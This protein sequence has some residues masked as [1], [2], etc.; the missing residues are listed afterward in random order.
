MAIIDQF[1]FH[2]ILLEID[3]NPVTFFQ[4]AKVFFLDLG[5]S[6]FEPLEIREVPYPYK[7]LFDQID[8]SEF[9]YSVMNNHFI[10][11]ARRQVLKS[12]G[13]ELDQ[14]GYYIKDG[15]VPSIQRELYEYC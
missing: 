2:P 1:P 11:Y 8:V 9:Q 3:L 10:E 15:V 5:I 14:D 6:V 4:F 13:Y 7:E 12:E